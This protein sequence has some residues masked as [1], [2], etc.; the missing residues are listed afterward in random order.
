MGNFFA[1]LFIVCLLRGIKGVETADEGDAADGCTC[2]GNYDICG[3]ELDSGCDSESGTLYTCETGLNPLP[4]MQCGYGC[5]HQESGSDV[6]GCSCTADFDFC[7]NS[8]FMKMD[9]CPAYDPTMLYSC[10]TGKLPVLVEACTSGCQDGGAK[11][12]FCVNRYQ[13]SDVRGPYP[14]CDTWR[15]V[16]TGDS[17]ESIADVCGIDYNELKRLN[18][19]L[20]MGN[21]SRTIVGQ[22]FCCEVDA[23]V[24]SDEYND[25]V[26]PFPGCTSSYQIRKGDT[27]ASIASD[28]ALSMQDFK[29][30]NRGLLRS[31]L[32]RNDKSCGKLIPGQT[33][34]CRENVNT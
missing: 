34:C 3:E 10:E 15:Q 17:L 31:W 33:V 11:N 16:Q 12:D 20:L 28:C 22:M 1:V 23:L 7:G 25:Y 27:C 19:G 24:P 26:P 14:G 29:L 13:P 32:A 4:K 2:S 9:G 8:T 5:S 6:C 30:L 21:S 18:S